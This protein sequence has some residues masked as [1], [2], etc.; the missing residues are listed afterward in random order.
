MRN[1]LA[2]HLSTIALT[3]V[4]VLIA[5]GVKWYA[6][7]TYLKA[8]ALF[9]GLEGT[10]LLSSALS[11]PR[12]IDEMPNGLL[13][14]IV[15]SFVEGRRLAYPIHYNPVFYYGGLV[16]IALSFVLSVL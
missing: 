15:W 3:V 16:F 5:A 14:R 6:S 11:P 2:E 7:I 13:A 4:A 9:F 1:V 12:D 10:V 8:V